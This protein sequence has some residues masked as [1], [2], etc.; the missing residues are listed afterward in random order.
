LTDVIAL[1]SP[2]SRL[3]IILIHCFVRMRACAGATGI[4]LLALCCTC[5][6]AQPL[7]VP[8]RTATPAQKLRIVGGLAGVNQY[9]QQEEPF[10][11]NTLGALSNG[12][13]AAE[14]VPFDRAGI[15][16]QDM[17]RL[18]QMGVI[19]FGTAQISRGSAQDA[20]FN[21]VDLAGLNPDMAT[22]RKTV[23]AFRPFL[24]HTLRLRY[25]I[26]LL[27]IYVYPAQMV[28]CNKP[29]TH[30]SDLSGLRVRVAGST[31]ADFVRAFGAIPVVTPLGDVMNHL[32]NG[33]VSCAV[34]G[35]MTGY[36]LGLYEVTTH[37][38][39]MPITWGLSLFAA[40]RDSWNALDPQL[41]VLLRDELPKLEQ[42]IWTASERETQ[43]GL[44][45]NTGSAQ[46]R[47]AR[48]GHMT[49]VPITAQDNT[50]RQKVLGNRI[51]PNW[52][53]RCGPTCAQTW[54]QTIGPVH[55][56]TVENEP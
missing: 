33:R 20:E 46:C 4:L 14:I 56:I 38:Y 26:E 34:T 50:L 27:A 28:F 1:E 31:V 48:K 39:A 7:P 10:W 32:R 54:N 55:G 16:A 49:E 44:A 25:G 35:S 30:L 19:P 2:L 18:I 42:R 52:L 5:V 40:N 15:P 29:I 22:L 47:A 6:A 53:R 9:V 3:L 43:E 24:E 21:A 17:L 51:L 45:C 36:T 41:R 11:T 23:T 13:F 37:I 8:D 12:R